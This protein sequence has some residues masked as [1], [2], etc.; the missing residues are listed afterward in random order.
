M[1]DRFLSYQSVV[2]NMT[3]L[4]RTAIDGLS[5]IITQTLKKLI[6][7]EDDWNHLKATRNILHI[8][9]EA[10][11]LL[12]GK[13]YPTLSIVYII[14]R[15]LKHSLSQSSAGEQAAIENVVK[16]HM[17]EAFIEHFDRKIGNE[18]KHATLVC[19]FPS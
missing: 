3:I 9:H 4:N 13:K 5:P 17:H 1:I 19:F 10:C 6:F 15:G 12:S 11:R 8:L 7:M 16:K 2:E 18:Q 14:T